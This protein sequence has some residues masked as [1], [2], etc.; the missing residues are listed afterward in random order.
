VATFVFAE[1]FTEGEAIAL[2]RKAFDLGIT[3]LDAAGTD[4]YN[5]SRL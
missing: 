1:S 2:M 3:L 5:T 4:T